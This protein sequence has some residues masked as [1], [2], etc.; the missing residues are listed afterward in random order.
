MYCFNLSCCPVEPLNR[1]SVNVAIVRNLGRHWL[2]GICIKS[3]KCTDIFYIQTG[4]P[5]PGQLRVG[6]G[7]CIARQNSRLLTL[8]RNPDPDAF[9][10]IKELPASLQ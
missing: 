3:P 9:I 1:P 10:G 7:Y 5:V 6:E 8:R 4:F 2:S